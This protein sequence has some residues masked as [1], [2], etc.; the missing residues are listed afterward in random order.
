MEKM[1]IAFVLFCSSGSDWHK[2][3][4]DAPST[5]LKKAIK[6]KVKPAVCGI[7]GQQFAASL[8]IPEKTYPK[9]LCQKDGE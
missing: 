8:I 7:M 5:I 1:V 4:I 3:T 2:C 9:I 6:M